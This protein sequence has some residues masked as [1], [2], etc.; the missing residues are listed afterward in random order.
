MLK[1]KIVRWFGNIPFARK[2]FFTFMAVFCITLLPLGSYSYYQ[3]KKNLIS[4]EKQ[5]VKEQIW[6]ANI[7]LDSQIKLYQSVLSSIL[8][9][10]QIRQCLEE[11]DIG[12]FDQYVMFSNILEPIIGNILSA[13]G[14]IIDLKIYTNNRTLQNH[15]KYLYALERLENYEEQINREL[16]YQIK[17]GKLIAMCQYFQSKGGYTHILRMEFRIKG[18]LDM[19]FE[20]GYLVCLIQKNGNVIFKSEG[21]DECEETW[22]ENKEFGLVQLAQDSYYLIQNDIKEANWKEYCFIP[23]DS[24]AVDVTEIVGATVVQMML[25]AIFCVLISSRMGKKLTVPLNNLQE[26]IKLV[27]NGNFTNSLHSEYTDEIG[28]LTNAFGNMTEKLNVMVNEVYASEIARRKA[29]FKMLQAQ[30]NPHFLYNTLSFINWSALRAGQKE[31]AKISRDISTYYR[32]ALNAGKM[33]TVVK[34]ELLNAKSY[35]DIQLAL[36]HYNF[37]VEYDIDEECREQE[38]ICNILQPLIE[39][40]LE[41]GI[42]KKRS[43]RG[44]L[45]IVVKKCGEN[46]LCEVMDN[47][48]GFEGREMEKLLISDSKGYGLKNV[49]ER[50]HIYYGK[51]YGIE[52]DEQDT[53]MTRIKIILPFK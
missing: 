20:K 39:N 13:N 31:I 36:H 51:E 33:T 34:E 16:T 1:R 44:F 26:N 40:A 19:L 21:I 18:S 41:H 42:D 12:Y 25:A 9:N 23:K 4:Q 5:N 8:Y 53:Q 11:D 29:E 28:N 30:M 49:N 52:L 32:T 14:E 22:N 2:I 46:L 7:M 27:E 43:G 48:P 45:K 35:V 17:D 15:S 6:Q 3:A 47:G 37:D 50:I 24:L 38:I 10:V